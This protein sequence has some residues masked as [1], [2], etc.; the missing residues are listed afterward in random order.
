VTPDGDVPRPPSPTTILHL[1]PAPDW[2][3]DPD[4]PYA[5]A[6]LATEGF[7]HCSPDEATTL[8]VATAFYAD[9]P[10]PLLVLRLDVTRLQAEV[11]HEAAS[12]V[13]PPGV[14]DDVLFP[15]VFGPLDRDAVTSVGE[16]GWEGRVAVR[17][18]EE[19][20]RITSE[21]TV[22]GSERQGA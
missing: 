8:A 18:W 5:P 6:S 15:H 10:R 7:V 4:R 17:I 14:S 13:P 12:P 19:D 16:V 20:P 3:A 2:A 21:T 22:R 1:V 9:A 11:V